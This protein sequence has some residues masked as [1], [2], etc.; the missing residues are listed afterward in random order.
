MTNPSEQ[1]G[2]LIDIFNPPDLD[3]LFKSRINR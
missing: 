1:F 2:M 3:P